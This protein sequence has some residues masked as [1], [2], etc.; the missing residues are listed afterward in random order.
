MKAYGLTV[1]AVVTLTIGAGWR[2]VV[3]LS[4]QC[5]F[6]LWA[7]VGGFMRLRTHLDVC[8]GNRTSI[9]WISSL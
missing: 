8:A 5:H 1:L 9:H 7:A 3:G 6:N 2:G 4:H